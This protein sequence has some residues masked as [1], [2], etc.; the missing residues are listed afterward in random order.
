MSHVVDD[1]GGNGVNEVSDDA[2]NQAAQVSV[3]RPRAESIAL[4]FKTKMSTR[5]MI[6]LAIQCEMVLLQANLANNPTKAM[7][8]YDNVQR[9]SD[10]LHLLTNFEASLL[11]QLD[12]D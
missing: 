12:V 7:T 9:L 5:K 10:T 2:A 1:R 6:S 11:A 4:N 3:V 8:H